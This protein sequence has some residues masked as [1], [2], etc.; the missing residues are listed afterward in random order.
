[1]HSLIIYLKFRQNIPKLVGIRAKQFEVSGL[2]H[3]KLEKCLVFAVGY[4]K[5]FVKISTWN[6][7]ALVSTSKKVN[8]TKNLQKFPSLEFTKVI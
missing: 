3:K 5:T 8:N 2:K 7:L 1:M 4:H 6:I